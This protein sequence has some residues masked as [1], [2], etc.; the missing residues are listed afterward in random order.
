[1]KVKVKVIKSITLNEYENYVLYKCL[2]N[3]NIMDL[4]RNFTNEEHDRASKVILNF[5][6]NLK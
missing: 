1:M 6:E 3:S 4:L 5:V 2:T